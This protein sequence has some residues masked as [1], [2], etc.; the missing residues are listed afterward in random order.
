M[1][2]IL[3]DDHV[4]VREGLK[5][6]LRKLDAEVEVYEAGSVEELIALAGRHSDLRLVLLDLKMPG[7]SGLDGLQQVI[8]HFPGVPVVVLSGLES[9]DVVETALELGATGYIPKSLSATAMVSA[10]QLVLSGERYIPAFAFRSQSVNRQRRPGNGGEPKDQLTVRE[11]EILGMVRKG[12]SNKAIANSLGLKE[13]TV[14][15]HL[16]AIFRKL[17]VENRVQAIQAAAETGLT[18]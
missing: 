18:G 6:F 7:M 15:S 11:R 2:I 13:V 16:Y 10:L 4:M 1:R 5:P 12:L 3:A 8:A 14:K 9:I 17:G